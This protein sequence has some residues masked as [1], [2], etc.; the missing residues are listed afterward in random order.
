MSVLIN[1]TADSFNRSPYKQKFSKYGDVLFGIYEKK[2]YEFFD[3]T[4]LNYV[5]TLI[6][7]MINLLN[8][9]KI[10]KKT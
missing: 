9:Q 6:S 7:T 8:M 2:N 3:G 4:N 1:F 10:T 5:L